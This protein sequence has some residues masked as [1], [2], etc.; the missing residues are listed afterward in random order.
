MLPCSSRSEKNNYHPLPQ[1]TAHSVYCVL[2]CPGRVV[3][4]F[5]NAFNYLRWTC[6]LGNCS[7]CCSRND[8]LDQTWTPAMECIQHVREGRQ[9]FRDTIRISGRVVQ[10]ESVSRQ[11]SKERLLLFWQKLD[12]GWKG[13]KFFDQTCIPAMRRVQH[14][15][16][17]LT[18]LKGTSSKVCEGCSTRVC[19][20][21][22]KQT[23]K[24]INT[25]IK[26]LWWFK[27]YGPTTINIPNSTRMSEYIYI[28]M[29]T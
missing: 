17:G 27:G 26:V 10:K 6:F 18:S 8:L 5:P 24:S 22:E 23:L 14:V 3:S 21:E 28:Y 9:V 29:Y 25:L 11:G 15:W 1:W 16:E 19:A 20:F 12:S 2:Q 13:R 4:C 7:L